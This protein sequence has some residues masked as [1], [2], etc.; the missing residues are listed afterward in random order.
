MLVGKYKGNKYIPYWNKTD[1]QFVKEHYDSKNFICPNC[2][3]PVI[4]INGNKVIKHFRHDSKHNCHSEPE[5]KAHLEMKQFF[6]EKFKEHNPELELNMGDNIADVYVHDLNLAIEVQYSPISL[7]VWKERTQ[8]YWDN[9]INVMW[10]FHKTLLSNR[11]NE[12]FKHIKKINYGCIYFYIE[13]QVIPVYYKSSKRWVEEF[14]SFETGE[15]YGG[16]WKYYKLK[17]E[18]VLGSN[19]S[20]KMW[21]MNFPING[22]TNYGYHYPKELKNES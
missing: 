14:D 13:R 19:V 15:T 21:D 1:Y 4:F 18:L 8:K 11:L 17:K 22:L 3:K 16:Y 20:D 6:Y 10:I 12:L 7:K 2:N 9:D 5:T